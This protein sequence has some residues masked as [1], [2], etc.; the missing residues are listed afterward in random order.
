[1]NPLLAVVGSGI[2]SS[3]SNIF[4]EA[5]IDTGTD[6]VVDK[7]NDTFQKIL[8]SVSENEY[9]NQFT[10]QVRMGMASATNARIMA[11][12]I[13]SQNKIEEIIAERKKAIDEAYKL[14]HNEIKQLKFKGVAG[15]RMKSLREQYNQEIKQVEEEGK[16][17]YQL[18]QTASTEAIGLNGG[19]G[20]LKAGHDGTIQNLK[21]NPSMTEVSKVIVDLLNSQGY[22]SDKTGVSNI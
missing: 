2:A 7:V 3:V 12:A 9:F 18:R 5:L 14:K 4:I 13:K 17:I 20:L 6:F 15:K 8:P 1:M 19:T 11:K 10:N 22:Y 16:R 21:P